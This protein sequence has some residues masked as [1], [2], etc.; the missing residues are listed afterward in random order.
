MVF[1]AVA[2]ASNP[3]SRSPP[4]DDKSQ[5]SLNGL[6]AAEYFLRLYKE[7]PKLKYF[8]RSIKLWAAN[9][10]IYGAISGFLGGMYV[11][12]IIIGMSW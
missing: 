6:I 4:M 5:R 3:L 9:H 12:P 7:H 11:T 2:Y 10:G 1:A 8:L